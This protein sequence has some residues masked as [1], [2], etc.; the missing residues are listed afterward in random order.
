MRKVF[1]IVF[2]IVFLTSCNLFFNRNYT[3]E[4][5]EIFKGTSAWQ[6][7]K[8]VKKQDTIRIKKLLEE[9][10]ELI[11][12]RE[13]KFGFS[14]VHWVMY[15]YEDTAYKQS[16][17]YYGTAKLLIRYGANPFTLGYTKD[18]DNNYHCAMW[19]ASSGSNPLPYVKLCLSSK[20]YKELT[21]EKRKRALNESLIVLSGNQFYHKI[22]GV[23]LLIE[24]GANIDYISHDGKNTPLSNALYFDNYK[25]VRYLIID[26]GAK[27]K[28]SVSSEMS[29]EGI[30]IYDLLNNDYTMNVKE[31]SEDYR[32]H[33]EVIKYIKSKEN[34]DTLL[35]NLD[36][37]H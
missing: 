28:Y 26:C 37:I 11:T 32:I 23:R 27:Y 9:N 13:P 2:F 15:N 10:P 16:P 12:Y 17:G 31:G 4:Y 6:I 8:S 14:L 3:A 22:D 29:T 18:L 21:D 36:T 19:D 1:F 25:I 24:Q 7:A 34:V 35:I 33:K 30:S 20:A 5:I